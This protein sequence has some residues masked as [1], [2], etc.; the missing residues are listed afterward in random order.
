MSN[1]IGGSPIPNASPGIINIRCGSARDSEPVGMKDS[2]AKN[3]MS[4]PFNSAAIASL[5][6]DRRGIDCDGEI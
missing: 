1:K 2:K 6:S 5:C 3:Q 4:L